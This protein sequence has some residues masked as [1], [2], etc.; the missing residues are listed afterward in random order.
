MVKIIEKYSSPI[1]IEGHTDNQPIHTERFPS[2][3]ELSVARAEA[4]KTYLVNR[5][6][7]SPSRIQTIGMGE[8]R[9]IAPNNSPANM[10][11]NRRAEIHLK[12]TDTKAEEQKT[13]VEEKTDDIPRDKTG[14]EPS[15][16]ETAPKEPDLSP[17][18]IKAKK[19]KRGGSW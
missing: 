4:V 18:P 10:Y 7:I 8:D 5:H 2:N 13:A 17:T 1:I 12:I 6:N 11:K 14:S 19:I 16:E 9:P 3:Y 15:E